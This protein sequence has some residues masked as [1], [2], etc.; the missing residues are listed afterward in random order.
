M[1]DTRRDRNLYEAC[2]ACSGTGRISGVNRSGI[3]VT[4]PCVCR[5]IRAIETGL[6]I[7]QVD[8]LVTAER[9]RLGDPAAKEVPDA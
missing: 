5:P 1:P 2:I 3:F 9:A 4:M 6:T 7:G 8:R